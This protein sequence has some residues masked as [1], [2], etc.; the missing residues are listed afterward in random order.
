[1]PQELPEGRGAQ[2][3]PQDAEGEPTLLGEI[4]YFFHGTAPWDVSAAEVVRL[5]NV[6]DDRDNVIAELCPR[7]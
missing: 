7:A 5:A 1:M 6:R 4:R 3:H 2:E